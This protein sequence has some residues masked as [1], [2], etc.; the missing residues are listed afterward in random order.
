MK[1]LILATAV[2]LIASGAYARGG[3][4]HGGS[5]FTSGYVRSNGTYVH[6]SGA[7]NPNRTQFDNYSTKG[8][9]NPYSGVVGTKIPTR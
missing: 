5:H 2:V 8:N 1:R 3:G 6:P 9:V 4:G 7:T